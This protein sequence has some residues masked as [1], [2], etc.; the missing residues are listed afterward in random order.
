M[1]RLAEAVILPAGPGDD[2]ALARVHVDA[3]RETYTGLLPR[4][5]LDAMNP[6]LHARRWRTLLSRPRTGEVVL[7]AEGPAGLV[8]YCHG[9]STGREAEVFTLYLLRAAQN[10]GTG[11]RLLAAT[12]RVLAADGADRLRIRVLNRNGRARGFYEHLGGRAA[13]ERAV[14]GWGGGLVETCYVWDDIA[15]VFDPCGS[16]PQ[17]GGGGPG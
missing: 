1:E 5:Y 12:A 6:R 8:G 13:G 10:G 4:A 9:A 7:A 2:I 16:H 17:S 3:W 15:A 11:R 14:G